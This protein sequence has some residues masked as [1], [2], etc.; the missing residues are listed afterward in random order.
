MAELTDFKRNPIL[1]ARLAGASVTKTEKL[2]GVARST[3]SKVMA[4]F[5]EEGKN[6]LIE[7]KLWKK[8]KAVR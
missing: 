5:E 6:L 8:T 2:F 7:A 1:G 4:S 3:V